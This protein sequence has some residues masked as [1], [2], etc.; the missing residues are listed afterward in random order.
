L[1]F[2]TEIIY[3]RR[4]NKVAGEAPPQRKKEEVMLDERKLAQV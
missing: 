4:K 1:K 2:V 3:S